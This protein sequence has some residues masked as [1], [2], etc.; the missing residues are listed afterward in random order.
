M[1]TDTGFRPLYS[2]SPVLTLEAAGPQPPVVWYP[3]RDQSASVRVPFHHTFPANTFY[4]INSDVL[5]YSATGLPDWLSFDA[6]AHSLSGT[7]PLAAFGQPPAS[8]TITAA[9]GDPAHRRCQ[10]HLHAHGQC[11]AA[12]RISQCARARRRP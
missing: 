6:A 3:I 5:T 12:G 4:D 11:R 2:L 1:V 7:P 8:I 9:D 10:R